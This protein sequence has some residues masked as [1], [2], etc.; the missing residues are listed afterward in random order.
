MRSSKRRPIISDKPKWPKIENKENNTNSIHICMINVYEKNE[1][2]ISKE[3]L[4]NPNKETLHR[5]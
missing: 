4:K 3:K 5:L 1:E 2:N